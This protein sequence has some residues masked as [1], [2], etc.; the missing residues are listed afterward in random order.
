MKVRTG[1]TIKTQNFT[2]SISLIR[3]VATKQNNAENNDMCF[4]DKCFHIYF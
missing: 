4:Y 2:E 1:I 3:Q